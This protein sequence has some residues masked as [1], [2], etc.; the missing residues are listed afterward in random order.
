MHDQE[1]SEDEKLPL[2]G[3]EYKEE[4]KAKVEL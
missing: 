3:I 4:V 2:I 1:R